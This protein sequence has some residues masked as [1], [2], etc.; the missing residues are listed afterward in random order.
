M[1]QLSGQILI[2]CLADKKLSSFRDWTL[3]LFS[4]KHYFCSVSNIKGWPKMEIDWTKKNRKVDKKI[5][6][7]LRP[8]NSLLAQQEK[9]KLIWQLVGQRDCLKVH[10][11]PYS[12][13]LVLIYLSEL[14]LCTSWFNRYQKTFGPIVE[15]WNSRQHPSHCLFWNQSRLC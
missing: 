3:F 2:N 6:R 14:F 12:R 10:G 1:D 4:L 13:T 7:S 8:D 15:I 5:I 11:R 9:W